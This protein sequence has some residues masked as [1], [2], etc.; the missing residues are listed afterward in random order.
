MRTT[1]EMTAM[2]SSARNAFATQPRATRA[3]VSR[4]LAR[5]RTLRTS[6]NPYFWAPTRSA[7]PGR[8]RVSFCPGSM[9]PSTPIRSRY[10]SSNSV[11]GIVMPIGEPSVRPCR[12]PDRISNRSVSN[13]CRPPRPWPCRRRAS[14]AATSLGEMGTSAG[15]P[16]STATRAFPC[17]SPAV[18]MRSMGL[19]IGTARRRRRTGGG[20]FRS[21]RQDRSRSGGRDRREKRGG[22]PEHGAAPADR[23]PLPPCA[24]RRRHGAVVS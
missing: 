8:G 19:I 2:P 13:R 4:A 12:T 20:R 6:S 7:C 15:I 24:D 21:R 17:D 9:L 18:S 11:L 23:R 14:S 3:A 16:S 1:W 5:S 22:G 10:F